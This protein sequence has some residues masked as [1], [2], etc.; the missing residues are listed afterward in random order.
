MDEEDSLCEVLFFVTKTA[1]IN[2]RPLIISQQLKLGTSLTIHCPASPPIHSQTLQVSPLTSTVLRARRSLR[3]TLSESRLHTC[4]P[5]YEAV[6]RDLR[7][8]REVNGVRYDS[9]WVTLVKEQM[10]NAV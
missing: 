2:H 9:I 10:I 6:S 7:Y 4:A 3:M 8:G 1:S 5:K